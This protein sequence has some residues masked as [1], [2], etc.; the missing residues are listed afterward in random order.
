MLLCMRTTVHVNDELLR[1]AKRRAADEGATLKA[2]FEEALRAYL[3]TPVSRTGY[4]FRW[5]T[6]KGRL[7]PGVDLDDRDTLFDIMEGRR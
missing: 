5:R 1:Q 6:E 7:M 4:V 2:V 3:A